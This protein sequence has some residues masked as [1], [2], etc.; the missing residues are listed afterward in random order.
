MKILYG[1]QATG[2]GH[3]TRAR[4]MAPKLREVGFEVDFL[5]SGRN[6][7]ELFD[8]QIFED[9]DCH[10][11][12]TFA[13]RNGQVSWLGTLGNNNLRKLYLDIKSTTK[14]LSSGDYDLVITDFEPITAWAARQSGIRSVALGHQYAF[15]Y[16]IP[17][18]GDRWHSRLFMKY[19]TPA[20]IKL[21]LH[22][23]HFEQ[24]IL[25]PIVH[26]KHSLP[27]ASSGKI[28]VYLPFDDTAEVVGA[29]QTFKTYNFECFTP[30]VKAYKRK[31]NIELKPTS[32]EEFQIS[33]ASCDGVICGAGFELVSE[34][35]QL[36]KKILVKPLAGQME[37]H[38][39]AL[40]LGELRLGKSMNKFDEQIIESWLQKSS[41]VQIDYP[42]VAKA[43]AQ[44]LYTEDPIDIQSL[45][46]RLWRQTKKWRTN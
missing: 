36:G 3:I 31:G 5:F 9:Y 1:V 14:R 8:M 25:P 42:D 24:A 2:N 26:L 43:V 38:S 28:L 16:K 10:P 4:A 30:A 15:D 44:C 17:Q 13:T 45:A 6:R 46:D 34:A 35:L 18:C 27:S 7:D 39:N 37:Q 33:L 20:S 19:F 23:H 41:S 21:G 40:A 11:G 29:L 32:L 22:W 12:M